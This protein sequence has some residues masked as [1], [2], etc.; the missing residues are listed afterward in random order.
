MLVPVILAGGSGTRLWPV[1]RETLPKQLAPLAGEETLLQQ[2]ARRIL[3]MAAPQQVITVGASHLDHLVERQLAAIDP[4]LARHRLL[5][6]V[7]RNTAAAVA[8]AALYAHKRMGA[9]ALLWVCPSD[10]LVRHVDRLHEALARALPVAEAGFLLT[11]G[12]EPT[13]PETGYGYIRAGEPL[14]DAPGVLR[15]TR[16]VEKPE[17]A[18]A[19]AMLAQGGHFWNSGMFLFGAV[20]ILDELEAHAPDILRAVEAAHGALTKAPGGAWQVPLASYEAVP[21]QPIDKAVME[22]ADRIAV[23]PC[24]PGWS[25]LGSWQALWEQLPRD[26]A[27]NAIQGDA[28]LHD[29]RDCLVHGESRLVACA[30]V[31]GLAVIE[32]GDAV[33]VMGRERSEAVRDLVAALKRAGR[34]EATAHGEEHRPWGRFKVLHEGPGFKVKEIVVEPGG[35]L[36][37]QSHEHRAEH[38]VVVAG[39]ARV[40]VGEEILTLEPNQSVH[41]PLGARHRMENPGE[42][43]M[44][45]IEVQCGAYLGED[46]IVRYEDVYGR[47]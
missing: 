6:P 27:G 20:R 29:A 10:H 31:Q 45:L 5:E 22:R 25:D 2:T 47:S 41:I 15:T 36:S 21:A 43:P 38:W 3:G 40:T 8:L 4:A 37:L 13:R 12:I 33:L 9:G 18:A 34:S 11:F 39:I 28:V 24:D 14:P 19:E 1:S 32:T 26:A 23:A 16:F 30:G 42:V 44:H 7:G 17:R 35:R 46:D